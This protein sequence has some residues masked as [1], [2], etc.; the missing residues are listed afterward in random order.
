MLTQSPE[1]MPRAAALSG[2][3]SQWGETVKAIV[4][5]RDEATATEEEVI[6]FCR[7]KLGGYERPRSVEFV[8]TLPRNP[9]GKVLKRQL[10]EPYWA[11][12][13]RRV[14]GS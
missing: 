14:A 13:K 1:A 4:V 8:G 11:G 10:R 5:L 12:Q 6:D 9:T 2:C 7:D 3:S